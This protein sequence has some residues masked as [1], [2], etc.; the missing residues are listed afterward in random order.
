MTASLLN[1]NE[2]NNTWV[3]EHFKFIKNQYYI[4]IVEMEKYICKK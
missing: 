3:F 1:L 2:T 4:A